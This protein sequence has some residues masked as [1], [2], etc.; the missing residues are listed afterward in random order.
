MLIATAAATS[1]AVTFAALIGAFRLARVA[2]GFV[3]PLTLAR[4]LV[5]LT[6]AVLVGS[7]IPWMGRVFVP[8][9]AMLVGGIYL[10]V[11][12][13]LRELDKRDLEL[14]RRVIGMRA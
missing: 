7:R 13:V 1:C 12:V 3:A 4:G 10:A 8:F 9:Q 5:A 14:V 2:G 11:L 6:V